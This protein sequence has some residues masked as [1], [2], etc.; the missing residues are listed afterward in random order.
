MI[1][2]VGFI[3]SVSL[4]FALT[5]YVKGALLVTKSRCHGVSSSI[6]HAIVFQHDQRQMDQCY[7]IN[8]WSE[9]PRHP[10]A[11]HI[12]ET[13]IAMSDLMSCDEA[14]DFLPWILDRLRCKDYT[15]YGELMDVLLYWK[16]WYTNDRRRRV[17]L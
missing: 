4:L 6:L 11:S 12:F 2:W 8:P 10:E 1:I 14:H 17:I 7:L 5:V 16:T 9:A 3:I 15:T 13:L